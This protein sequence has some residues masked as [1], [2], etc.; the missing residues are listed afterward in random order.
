[1]SVCKSVLAIFKGKQQVESV[2]EQLCNAGFA[3]QAISVFLVQNDPPLDNQALSIKSLKTL[4][5]FGLEETRAQQYKDKLL[6]GR[7]G[8]IM[9]NLGSSQELDQATLVFKRNNAEEILKLPLG[10]G[11]L[12]LCNCNTISCRL[13]I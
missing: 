11:P 5:S 4:I 2:R 8:L 6:E 10:G 13:Q 12:Q 1:M 3:K 9:V 7:T